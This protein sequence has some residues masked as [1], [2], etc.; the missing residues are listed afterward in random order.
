VASRPGVVKRAILYPTMRSFPGRR[1]ALRGIPCWLAVSALAFGCGGVS[2]RPSTV[3]EAPVLVATPALDRAVG[4]VHARFDAERALASAAVVDRFF[5]VRGNAGYQASL[6]HVRDG[7]AAAGVERVR[8]LELGP[9]QP[10]WT[11]HA[12]R[13]SLIGTDGAEVPIVAFADEAGRDRA[14]LLIG[15]D[16]IDTVELE[17]VRAD[18][19][20]RGQSARGRLVLGEG[21]PESLFR[22]H[23]EPRGALGVLVRNL[24]PIHHASAHPDAA[25]FGALPPHEGRLALGFSLSGEDHRVLFAATE[26]GVARV[27]VSIDV[28]VGRSAATAVEARIEGSDHDAGAIVFSTHVD[29]PGA[30]DNAS[31]VAALLELATALHRAIEE[32][33]VPP[34]ARTLIFLWGQEMEVSRAWLEGAGVSVAAAFVLDMVGLDP[35]LGAPF[36]IERLPDPGAVWLRAPDLPSGWGT[37]DVEEGSLHGHFLSDWTRASVRAVEASEGR[38]WP[39]RA[40]PYE[41]G[42]DHVSFLRRGVPAVLAWHFPDDAYHT[43]RDRM[44]RVRGDELRRVGAALGGAALVLAS[45]APSDRAEV[46][47]VVRQA[48]LERLGWAEDAART[49]ISQPAA[50]SAPGGSSGDGSDVA[51]TTELRVLNAWG[52]WYDEA[53]SALAAWD[54]DALA[55][56][57]ALRSA[58]ADVATRLLQGARRLQEMPAPAAP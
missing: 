5:R 10:T 32:G 29:E 42:S 6:Q 2:A 57:E 49:A 30:N 38:P 45:S 9:V 35:A 39:S 54:R 27:R 40:H 46:V 33:A 31:G 7:L 51:R 17:V 22:E 25:Q 23:V 3:P 11:P 47:E 26:R 44:E 55:L 20:H 58:R 14:S 24:A 36:L 43:S 37:A 18:A 8:T 53:L 15:S 50:A 19:V 56:R 28:T 21:S 41:G 48:A 12:A 1:G 16:A 13:L 52:R 34:P 4:A